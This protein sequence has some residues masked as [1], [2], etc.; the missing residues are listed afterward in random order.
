MTNAKK[1]Y[2]DL[3]TRVWFNN[4]PTQAENICKQEQAKTGEKCSNSIESLSQRKNVSFRSFAVLEKELLFH[5]HFPPV[6]TSPEAPPHH[7]AAFWQRE[8]ITSQVRGENA[9]TEPNR[10]G[11]VD[12]TDAF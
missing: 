5:R 6:P 9:A 10:V 4:I 8:P 11:P 7:G 12:F 1:N 2:T 3:P